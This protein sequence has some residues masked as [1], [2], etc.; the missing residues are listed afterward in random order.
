MPMTQRKI[1]KNIQL[2]DPVHCKLL[3]LI[4]TRQLPASKK[5]N[6]D[7]TKI[8]LLHNQYAQGNLLVDSDGLIV[9]KSPNAAVSG[10]LISIPPSLFPGIVSALH[11]RLDHPSKSQLAGL[12][13]RYFYMPGWR[14]IVDLVT[15]N[16]H[17][18]A[19]IRTLPK[20]LL[21]DSST[22]PKSVASSF[23][24]D[25]I[26]RESQ[27]ILI[28]REQLSQ[29]TRG[30]II[31]DQKSVTLQNALLSLILDLI[32][33][34]GAEVIVDG[35]TS[36]QALER[37]AAMENSLLNKL[38]IKITVGRLLNKNKNPSAE[39]AIR[40]V[41]KEILRHTNRSG[42]ITTMDL[43][44]VLRNINSR[45]R[46]NNLTPKE[47][48]FRRDTM[49]NEPRDINDTEVSSQQL[50]NKLKSSEYSQKSKRRFKTY[51]SHQD[52]SIGDLVL[53]RDYKS[54]NMPRELFI[55]EDQTEERGK[56]YFL[57]RKLNKSLRARLYRALPDE[58]ISAPGQDYKTPE[59][60]E[61]TGHSR[62]R[63]QAALKANERIR[64]CVN[65]LSLAKKPK[66]GWNVDDQ[67]L[68]EDHISH[69]SL[70]SAGSQ[71]HKTTSSSITSEDSSTDSENAHHVGVS[72]P[73]PH[74][75]DGP[76]LSWDE[77]P[78]QYRLQEVGSAPIDESVPPLPQ[79]L[80]STPMEL[81][82]NVLPDTIHLPRQRNRR[83]ATSEF[84]LSRSDAF[85]LSQPSLNQGFLHCPY[86]SSNSLS[87]IPTPSTPSQ[88]NLDQVCDVSLAL[89]SVDNSIRS[90]RR[91]VSQ[92]QNYRVFHNSG[93]RRPRVEEEGRPRRPR[94]EEEGR[95]RRPR[96][97]E[98]GGKKKETS[99]KY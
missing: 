33:D 97:E 35:A 3:H 47:I 27:K 14:A 67:I 70:G 56:T 58:L 91:S 57:I 30:A 42:P 93:R 28:V 13:A 8:K 60:D 29:F 64:S 77:S 22:S 88:V 92:P 66:H 31:N 46:Y 5:R 49:T 74:V 7:Y 10:T 38:K 55:I 24:A 75:D 16:C 20:V 62:P 18:C 73:L 98:E 2:K 65:S 59:T 11:I 76:E 19:A 23:A 26:E 45:I 82:M 34:T 32:P 85:R 50:A 37:E 89:Q 87:R 99:R 94:V 95:P 21:E 39:N 90:N 96:V 51:T 17:Q 9:V 6:G 68:Y 52:F 12:I 44:L 43:Q 84:E 15:D 86:T 81:Q 41:Q 40:E 48:L 83:Q 78:E 63:R 61:I 53:L 79:P 71:D 72:S 25:I 1:W 54:K 36:F 80:S 69:L 4:Q